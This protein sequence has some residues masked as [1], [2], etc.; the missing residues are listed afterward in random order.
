MKTVDHK[1]PIDVA[2]EY[3]HIDAL[4]KYFDDEKNSLPKHSNHTIRAFIDLAVRH[5]DITLLPEDFQ[6]QNERNISY[7]IRLA[8]RHP[9]G[10]ELLDDLNLSGKISETLLSKQRPADRFTPLMIAVKYQN[11]ECVQYF[12][13]VSHPR[14]DQILRETS[15]DF[16]R[17]VFHICAEIPNKKITDLLLEQVKPCKID[18]T[19]KDV[20][21]NT[22]LHICV[23]KENQYMC[24][25]L[26]QIATNSMHSGSTARSNSVRS[27]NNS[28]KLPQMLTVRNNNGLTSFHLATEKGSYD[29][30]RKMTEIV[31]NPESLIEN[32]DEQL[33]T[34]LH[35]AAF[36][37]NSDISSE[38]FP[39]GSCELTEIIF[40][41]Y[42]SR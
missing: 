32:R 7:I 38:L 11:V 33:R 2:A 15:L 28:S 37:G 34:S 42:I 17:T 8:C 16:Q 31:S 39:L 6:T 29:I 40:R 18:L 30:V 1:N 13:R 19:L 22:P 27:T 12:L 35:I 14:T 5:R 20:M 10:H 41:L 21:G 26:L 24:D 23:E 4:L 9:N 36:Q 25:K 3:G